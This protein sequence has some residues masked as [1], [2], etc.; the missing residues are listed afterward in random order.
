MQ[1]PFK[2]RGKLN[3]T[4]LL[5]SRDEW[6]EL[7][8]VNMAYQRLEGLT[9]PPPL[10]D[11][12]SD[13][14]FK[15]T[16][17]RWAKNLPDQVGRQQ[18]HHPRT[19]N[20]E[21][22]L[23]VFRVS[24]ADAGDLHYPDRTIRRSA[25]GTSIRSLIFNR[26]NNPWAPDETVW[27]TDSVQSGSGNRSVCGR[28]CSRATNGEIH[29]LAP[30]HETILLPRAYARGETPARFPTTTPPVP[31]R[32]RSD[33]P[34]FSHSISAKSSL[35]PLLE[36]SSDR[37]SILEPI[38]E[39][40]PES[41]YRASIGKS[42]ADRFPESLARRGSSDQLPSVYTKG[43]ATEALIHG[44]ND[45][46]ERK[47]SEKSNNPRFCRVCEEELPIFKCGQCFTPNVPTMCPTCTYL[48]GGGMVP[49]CHNE[50]THTYNATNKY[51]GHGK[52]HDSPFEHHSTNQSANHHKRDIN[53]HTAVKKTPTQT[54]NYGTDS[55]Y[56]GAQSSHTKQKKHAGN[57][58]SAEKNLP[59]LNSHYAG[60]S[61][62]NSQ[63]ST[64]P[65]EE[66][67]QKQDAE[68]KAAT[69]RN[70]YGIDSTKKSS[71]GL[72][73]P[74]RQRTQSYSS[75]RKNSALPKNVRSGSS[76][77]SNHKAT[78]DQKKY[79]LLPSPEMR[80]KSSS[81]TLSFRSSSTRYDG[82][83]FTNAYKQDIGPHTP[84]RV[85]S[86][87]TGRYSSVAE[88]NEVLRAKPLPRTPDPKPLPRTPAK[89]DK[90]KPLPQ[91]PS[92]TSDRDD[93]L[94]TE[95]Q[96]RRRMYA[97]TVDQ[98]HDLGGA[99]YNGA[100]V[101][102]TRTKKSHDE[103]RMERLATKF[104][105]MGQPAVSP[106]KPNFLTD[107]GHGAY[108]SGREVGIGEKIGANLDEGI[109]RV[110]RTIAGVKHDFMRKASVRYAKENTYKPLK[111]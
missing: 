103:E 85:D 15:I 89:S 104:F 110:N 96:I 17:L 75:E 81:P 55:I 44:N 64:Y 2:R 84:K 69:Q 19:S 1:A 11:C 68:K 14:D 91:P 9:P 78:H 60:S 42:I 25:S 100:K 22:D 56:R 49:D 10:S 50:H 33:T 20:H 23:P 36:K 73:T 71:Q 26:A 31:K 80:T 108:T 57:R 76:Y 35:H 18:Q 41:F 3:G 59:V 30:D 87:L 105:G 54:T 43:K 86:T 93:D 99:Y 45:G 28:P 58:S 98:M 109:R 53:K 82:S 67:T 62:A 40:P 21:E 39:E 24:K 37:A 47:I 74:Y 61:Y 46:P 12:G 5:L 97:E 52:S 27:E 65:H 101:E 13:Y 6:K 51:R 107:Q 77:N 29:T 48:L 111:F 66:Q 88:Y 79:D 106:T 4:R 90:N 8:Y 63:E 92:P 95:E 83:M 94:E 38:S 70:N 7:Y 102:K 34:S 32:R 16:P 72:D